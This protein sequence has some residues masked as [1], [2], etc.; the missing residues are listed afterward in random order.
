MFGSMGGCCRITKNPDAI[1]RDLQHRG[2]RDWP[3]VA[4]RVGWL[5][6]EDCEAVL[7]GSCKWLATVASAPVER[8]VPSPGPQPAL[9]ANLPYTL[10]R[11]FDK[12]RL[13]KLVAEFESSTKRG[14]DRS[15]AVK[16]RKEFLESDPPYVS[17]STVFQLS[18]WCKTNSPLYWDGMEVA[19]RISQLLFGC[20][21]D[22]DKLNA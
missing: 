11:N 16:L 6:W 22:R 18:K 9:G 20:V 14:I 4:S 8:N 5:T 21:V 2:E 10:D 1:A 12:P 17:R 13:E 15:L 3:A 7:P 19:R